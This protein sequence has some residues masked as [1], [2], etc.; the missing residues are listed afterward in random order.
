MSRKAIV[1]EAVRLATDYAG[2]NFVDTAPLVLSDPFRITA[3]G[4]VWDI[5]SI[6]TGTLS[7]DPS[8]FLSLL[9]DAVTLLEPGALD[10]FSGTARVT[11]LFGQLSARLHKCRFRPS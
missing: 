3:I 2:S 11:T 1:T 7:D 5:L 10:P 8:S 4:L 9:E 6:A